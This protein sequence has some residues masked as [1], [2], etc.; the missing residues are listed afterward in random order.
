MDSGPTGQPVNR[1]AG[2]EVGQPLEGRPPERAT[3]VLAPA[4]GHSGD[5]EGSAGPAD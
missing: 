1:G 3:V 4:R 5:Q 2:Q